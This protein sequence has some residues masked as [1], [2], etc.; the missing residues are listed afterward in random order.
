MFSFLIMSGGDVVNEAIGNNI[1]FNAIV[2]IGAYYTIEF[3]LTAFIRLGMQT[4]YVERKDEKTYLVVQLIVGMLFGTL[5]FLFAPLIV[6][7]FGIT[8]EQK[9]LLHGMLMIMIIYVPMDACGTYLFSVIRLQ[10]KLVEYRRAMILFYAVSIISNII[11]I[12][13][14]R[15]PI[16]VLWATILGYI[17]SIAYMMRKTDWTVTGK[18]MKNR[19]NACIKYG[20]PLVGEDALKR[21]SGFIMNITASW[22]PEQY[23][24]IHT[25]CFNAAIAAESV[26][27]AYAAAM[28]VLIPS[29]REDEA[30]KYREERQNLT[31]YR[32]Q[33]APIVFIISVAMCFCVT[34][35]THASVDLPTCLFY[36]IFYAMI[37]IPVVFSTPL[38]DFLTM[39]GKTKTVFWSTMC[40]IPAYILFP[41]AGAALQRPEI[42]LVL[43]GLAGFAQV[44]IRLIVY[45]RAVKK[46]DIEKEDGLSAN[47]ALSVIQD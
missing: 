26:T 38:K 2:V 41:L 37:F 35:I 47:D 19:I 6:N 4:Y 32:R 46:M 20:I 34:L 17:P 42:G 16:C 33:T 44:S 43:F 15:Q 11:F 5:L 45:R 14:I 7:L 30:E 31:Q 40:G 21:I 8:E 18:S 39:Q 3:V 36:E 24:A 23:F 13:T 22:L 25:I 29:K 12:F 28:F 10:E 27:D 9:A 1:S